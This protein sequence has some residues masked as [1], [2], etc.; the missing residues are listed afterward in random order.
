[1]NG[2]LGCLV[3]LCALVPP[4]CGE[5]PA[6][7]PQH[8]AETKPSPTATDVAS[9]PKVDAV[10]AAPASASMDAP[11]QTVVLTMAS[12]NPPRDVTVKPSV[13]VK[14]D[15][16]KRGNLRFPPSGKPLLIGRRGSRVVIDMNGDGDLTAADGKGAGVGKVVMAPIDMAG[17][18]VEYPLRVVSASREAI[19]LASAAVLSGRLG[20][21][22]LFLF[23]SN[24]NGRF[25]Q[26][27]RDRIM[28]V[29]EDRDGRAVTPSEG[30]ASV[31]VAMA[32][33]HAIGEKLV[34][35]KLA[36]DGFS[37]TATPYSG[38]TVSL[39]CVVTAG[40]QECSVSLAE[41][42]GRYRVQLRNGAKVAALPGE[43]RI[44]G[45]RTVVRLVT[46]GRSSGTHTMLIQKGRG[47]KLSISGRDAEV[48]PGPPFTLG[49]DVK[50]KGSGVKELKVTNV[51]LIG[52]AGERYKAV[53]RF[54]GGESFVKAYTRSGGEEK[55][56]GRLEYG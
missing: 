50:I 30:A 55:M 2:K 23:D 42:R 29:E 4:A 24:A 44:D 26:I 10:D 15:G 22:R 21:H 54:S 33:I 16:R 53:F 18:R 8:V 27:G 14:L 9:G 37:L 38:D 17:T 20:R 31:G 56:F 47:G 41:T 46:N 32:E 52:G 39:R 25:G 28:I 43:Y 11:P 1:M 6:R 40:T 34:G 7:L 48:A 13:T 19:K 3:V 51:Y 35:L 12:W 36:A 49:F 5:K 45:G